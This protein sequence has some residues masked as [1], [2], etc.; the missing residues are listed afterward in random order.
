MENKNE[1]LIPKLKVN[2]GEDPQIK[3]RSIFLLLEVKVNRLYKI[4]T[5]LFLCRSKTF[6]TKPLTFEDLY[7]IIKT[8]TV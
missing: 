6:F 3:L 1:N 7:D 2:Q 8:F 4:R 5:K